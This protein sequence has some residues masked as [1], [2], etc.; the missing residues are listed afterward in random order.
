V[1]AADDDLIIGAMLRRMTLF[2]RLLMGWTLRIMR[3]P[4]SGARLRLPSRGLESVTYYLLASWW[5]VAGVAPSIVL[6]PIAFFAPAAYPIVIA[7]CFFLVALSF[8]RWMNSASAARRFRERMGAPPIPGFRLRPPPGW[9]TP[10]E[11]FVP[12][13]GWL[14]D[15]SWPKPPKNWAYWARSTPS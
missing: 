9:P 12:P 8:V 2:E 11:G 5:L 10:P 6:L 13:R 3:N 7:V 1:T 4:K 15:A 14:P